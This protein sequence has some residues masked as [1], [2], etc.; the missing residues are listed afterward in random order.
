MQNQIWEDV[1]N[2]D[3]LAKDIFTEIQDI[4]VKA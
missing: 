4:K 1:K 3:T 2:V